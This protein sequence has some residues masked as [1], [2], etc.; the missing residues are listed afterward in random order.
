MERF[1][2]C[3]DMLNDKIGRGVS[4]LLIFIMLAIGTATI[5][6]YFFAKPLTIIWPV[7]KQIFGILVLL[8]SP[9]AMLAGKHIRVEILYD[10]FPPW[11][12]RVSQLVSLALFLALTGALIWQ[13]ITMA[14]MSFM[15]K[16]VSSL[17]R[18]IPVYPFKIFMPI[19]IAIFLLQGIAYFLRGKRNNPR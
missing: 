4:L 18:H 1:F 10:Q 8:G 15:L 12:K 5:S 7:I 3:I 14:K 6:R 13:G 16:E 2:S 17:S 9:Y 19:G 11:L